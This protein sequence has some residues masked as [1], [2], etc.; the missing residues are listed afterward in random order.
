VATVLQ[1]ACG[2]CTAG[3]LWLYLLQHVRSTAAQATNHFAHTL[4]ELQKKVL[5]LHTAYCIRR[6]IWSHCIYT[7]HPARLTAAPIWLGGLQPI[8][9]V[10]RAAL[11]QSAKHSN[12]T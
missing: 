8:F 11:P 1:A 3:S 7:Q 12:L 9:D 6:R 10:W 4:L 2:Y 5:K